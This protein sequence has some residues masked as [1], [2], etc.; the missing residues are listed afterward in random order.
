[1]ALINSRS[2]CVCEEQ[3]NES[4]RTIIGKP[5]IVADCAAYLGTPENPGSTNSPVPP[6]NVDVVVI[7][8]GL[9]GLAAAYN[10]IKHDSAIKIVILEA[11]SK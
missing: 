10:I 9:S 4:S 3:A 8:A 1:M 2:K 5:I 7:G 11:K 6:I